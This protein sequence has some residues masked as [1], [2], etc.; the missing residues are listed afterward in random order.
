MFEAL[1]DL[2]NIDMELRWHC[3]TVL[4]ATV[5]KKLALSG[6]LEPSV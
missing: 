1:I 3:E 2:V 4:F 6:I 5:L